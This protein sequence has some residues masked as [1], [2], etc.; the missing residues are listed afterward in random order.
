MISIKYEDFASNSEL[1][2]KLCEMTSEPLKLTKEGCPDLIV[3]EADSFSKRMKALEL[4]EKL[5]DS[6]G[7]L[8]LSP[9]KLAGF[10]SGS[11]KKRSK[12]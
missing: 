10:I 9:E 7:D 3:M 2:A 5:L 4:R 1:F 6:S 8:R 11:T 12:S